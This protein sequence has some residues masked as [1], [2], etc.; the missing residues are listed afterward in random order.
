MDTNCFLKKRNSSPNCWAP[1][2]DDGGVDSDEPGSVVE[3]GDDGDDRAVIVRGVLARCD[4]R[5]KN[6][7]LRA[8][9]FSA[10]KGLGGL[11]R[12]AVDGAALFVV[13]E[14]V[15]AGAAGRE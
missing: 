3:Q 9:G 15:E 2:S 8:A 10:V 11:Y 5:R 14:L 7:G 12:P 4:L 13:L 6:C 1:F